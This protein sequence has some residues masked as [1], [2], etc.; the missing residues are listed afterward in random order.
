MRRKGTT[1]MQ[2]M[3]STGQLAFQHFTLTPVGLEITGKPT[4]PEWEECGTFLRRAEGAVQWWI[5]DWINYGEWAYGDKY[6]HAT[7]MTGFDYQTLRNSAWVAR[8]IDV[9]LRRDNISYSIYK[10]LAVLNAERQRYWLARVI[11]EGLT[12]AQLRAEL[13]L[14]QRRIVAADLPA[15]KFRILYADPPWAYNDTGSG[16]DGFGRADEHYPTMSIDELCA[17][18]I[19]ALVE[20]DAVL[21]LWVTSPLLGECWPVIDAWGFTYKTSMV[22][23]KQAHNYGHYVS[24]RHECL[25]ICTRGSCTPD[26]PTPMPESVI[27]VRRSKNHS[28]KPEYFRNVIEQLYPIG[29]RLELFGRRDVEGWTVYGN[30][31]G[32]AV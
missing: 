12:V 29:R 32:L 1:A 8:S 24:V 13:R 10:E 27:T 28:E 26:Q 4:V 15:G 25:L 19:A 2:Y 14:E 30:Q 3:P 18:P 22:W 7:E 31:L 9:S 23:D 21:F 5:G 17:L 11:D 20:D 6:R 16:A